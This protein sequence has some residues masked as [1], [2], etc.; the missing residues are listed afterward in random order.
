MLNVIVLFSYTHV[1]YLISTHQFYLVF[2]CLSSLFIIF[3]DGSYSEFFILSLLLKPFINV[4][5]FCHHF[6]F[7]PY[8]Y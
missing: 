5:Y 6:I 2:A 8:K 3:G 7:K 1:H 4:Y